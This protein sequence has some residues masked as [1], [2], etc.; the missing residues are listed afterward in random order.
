MPSKRTTAYDLRKVHIPRVPSPDQREPA[1][2]Y[3]PRVAGN[4]IK[5]MNR[6]ST[7]QLVRCINAQLKL[8]YLMALHVGSVANCTN[9]RVP[10]VV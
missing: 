8:V 3:L 1:G 10:I 5:A 6:K 4:E 9:S 2:T 7:C